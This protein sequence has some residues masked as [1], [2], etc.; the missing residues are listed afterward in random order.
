[1]FIKNSE[2][3]DLLE[4]LL[5][6]E[7]SDVLIPKSLSFAASMNKPHLSTAAKAIL[8]CNKT[9]VPEMIE[10][11]KAQMEIVA[12][13]AVADESGKTIVPKEKKDEFLAA[14][15]TLDAERL[16]TLKSCGALD[17]RNQEI[18]EYNDMLSEEIDLPLVK[19]S[20]KT[21][22]DTL[23]VKHVTALMPIIKETPEEI[24]GLL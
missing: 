23:K 6:L 20:Y 18:K 17:K 14:M 21:L 5:D 15:K 8:D 1:M 24:A 7:K 19:T 16:P 4:A 10:F 9:N 2:V 12:T 22:P 3:L 13:F 11:N